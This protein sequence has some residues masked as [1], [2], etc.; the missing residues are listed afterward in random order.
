MKNDKPQ[1]HIH[2][3]LA[4]QLYKATSADGKVDT[5]ILVDLVNRA[6]QEHDHTRNMCERAMLLMSKEMEEKNAELEKN[7]LNLE[8]LVAERTVELNNEKESV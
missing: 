2:R 7:K 4:R 6:Y 5:D 1:V 3:L 8:K